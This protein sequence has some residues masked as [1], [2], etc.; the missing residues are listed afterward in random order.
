MRAYEAVKG[1]TAKLHVTDRQTDRLTDTLRTKLVVRGLY[2]VHYAGFAAAPCE[3]NNG[4]RR[5]APL[6]ACIFVFMSFSAC[7]FL[8]QRFFF[9]LL[10]P[11]RVSVSVP[12]L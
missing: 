8:R 5:L 12:W 11:Y 4:H 6:F 7:L 1:F 3:C 10:L 2:V 9:V